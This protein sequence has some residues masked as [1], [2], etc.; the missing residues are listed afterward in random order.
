MEET[1]TR[2]QYSKAW[3]NNYLQISLQLL[4]TIIVVAWVQL[5]MITELLLHA[6]AWNLCIYK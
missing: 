3:P 1:S 2:V 5:I 4:Y 6:T